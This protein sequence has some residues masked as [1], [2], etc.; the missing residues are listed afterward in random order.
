VTLQLEMDLRWRG[1]RSRW[2]KPPVLF[3]PRGFAV[4]VVAESLARPFVAAHHY[5]GEY[6]AARLEGW[7]APARGHGEDPAAWLERALPALRLRR[8]RHP[9]NLVYVFRL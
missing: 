2:V 8:V 1:R 5:E 9:G 3:N 4:D 7:G 6:P